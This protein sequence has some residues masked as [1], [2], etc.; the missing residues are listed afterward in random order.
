MVQYLAF[1]VG[2]LIVA[3]LIFAATRPNTFRVERTTR[4][5]AP[6]ERIFALINDFH[7]WQKWTPYDKD[8]AMTKIYSGAASGVG[9]IYEWEGDAQVGKGTAQITESQPASRITIKLDFIKPFEAHNIA[10]FTLKAGSDATQLTWAM[11]GTQGFM[12]KLMGLFFSMDK[13]AGKDFE[14]GLAR[15][16]AI[17]EAV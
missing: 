4:I 11:H 8:P 14:I 9:A 15:I 10:E 13:M 12:V 7:L 5:A 17:A 1:I 16:K 3:M 2:A 6:A